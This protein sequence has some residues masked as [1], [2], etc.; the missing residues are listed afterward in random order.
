MI[1]DSNILDFIESQTS[2]NNVIAY[3]NFLCDIGKEALR[4]QSRKTLHFHEIVLNDLSLS[5]RGT[6]GMLCLVCLSHGSTYS[7]SDVVIYM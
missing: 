1:C 4:W 2:I 5:Y 6:V 3:K 7:G